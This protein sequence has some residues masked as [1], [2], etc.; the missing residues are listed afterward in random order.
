MSRD[1]NSVVHIGLWSA[2]L[3]ETYRKGET[4]KLLQK[5][6]DET[7]NRLI[8]KFGEYQLLFGSESFI[9]KSGLLKRKNK[10]IKI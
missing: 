2:S 10:H 9:S 1:G 4:Y 6:R 3:G 5:L 7:K 8:N